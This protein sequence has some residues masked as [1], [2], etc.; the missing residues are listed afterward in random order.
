MEYTSDMGELSGFGGGYEATCRRMALAGAIW[1]RDLPDP[2]WNEYIALRDS[3]DLPS[4][5]DHAVFRGLD[6]AV[7]KAAPGC[8]GAMHGAAMNHALY[9]REHG[10]DDYAQKMRDKKRAR[11][12][13]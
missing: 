9:I 4:A 5:R 6:A 3:G 13:R 8:S 1:L 10:W 11:G 7:L 12:G 2:E